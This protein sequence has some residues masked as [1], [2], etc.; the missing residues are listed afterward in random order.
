MG[1]KKALVSSNSW[2]RKSIHI[3]PIKGAGYISLALCA[4]GVILFYSSPLIF[5]QETLQ[6]K[7]GAAS[8]V[9]FEAFLFFVAE[10]FGIMEIRDRKVMGL[11]A[12]IISIVLFVYSVLFLILVAASPI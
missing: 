6:S 7:S 8:F 3:K 1:D 2:L 10:A 11:V 12:T 5:S 4:V 9:I